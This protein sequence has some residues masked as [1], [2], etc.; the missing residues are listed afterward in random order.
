MRIKEGVIIRGIKPEMVLGA[1]IVNSIFRKYGVETVITSALDGQHMTGS[2]HYEG[3][4][5]DFRSTGFSEELLPV[6][7][8]EMRVCLGEN[9]DVIYEATP[10]HF[11]VEYDP[12]G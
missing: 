1:T 3:N 2:K 8:K 7:L 5:L 10:P 11:H 6:V 9:F 12:K 4:A